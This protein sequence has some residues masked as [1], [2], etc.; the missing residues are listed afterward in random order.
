M[1]TQ[2]QT[3]TAELASTTSKSVTLDATATNGNILI[4]LC[5]FDKDAGTVTAPSGFS[6]AVVVKADI[7]VTLAL[8]YKVSDGTEDTITYT[9]TTSR[10]GCMWVGEY[11]GLSGSTPNVAIITNDNGTSEISTISTGTTGATTQN[12]TLAI[13]AMGSDTATKTD[14]GAAWTNSFAQ[15]A[16]LGS[17][18]AYPGFSVATK[19]LTSTGTVESTFSTTDVGDQMAAIAIVWAEGAGGATVT[20]IDTDGI[21]VDGQ[22]N[23]PFNTTN[24]NDEIS[25][26]K[27]TSGAFTT[28]CT[29]VTSTSGNGNFDI[30]DV[31]A[32]T[33]TT[34]GA[35]FETA[36]WPTTYK[37][38][39]GTDVDIALSDPQANNPK[40]GWL[41]TEVSN[42]S[43]VEGA[44][45]KDL[46]EAV[47]DTSQVLHPDDITIG[48]DGIITT[49]R[50]TNTD[51]QYWKASTGEYI[52]LTIL[53]ESESIISADV[54]QAQTIDEPT[55]NQHN[56]ISSGQCNQSQ[57]LGNVT[58]TQGSVLSTNDINQSQVISS[59]ALIQHNNLSVNNLTQ[60]QATDNITLTVAHVLQVLGLTQSQSI[61]TAA[62][63]QHN[64]LNV[65]NITQNQ[66]V[67]NVILVDN[68]IILSVDDLSQSQLLD[69]PTITKRYTL[70][71]NN[72]TQSQLID[73]VS[74]NV[75]VIGYVK[76]EISIFSAYNGKIKVINPTKIQ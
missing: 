62:L 67:D 64:N 33:S 2:V 56:A 24:F 55:L 28:N 40:S 15:Q 60:S 9:H 6:T 46:G 38:T 35:P 50:T 69:K 51:C 68:A 53:L 29:G 54:S 3:K 16:Y 17:S 25:A 19:S 75:I 73:A 37:L 26:V 43:N 8:C 49:D 4:A 36:S 10:S 57:T 30:P 48:S 41:V 34:V 39:G 52:Q 20:A 65:D 61:D 72:L 31:S 58:L 71:V 23:V 27:I 18:S 32:Y 59:D 66:T 47:P 42:V 14:D 45:S 70:T 7:S 44:F 76:G 5:S 22:Q 13:V 21:T 11:S 12:N 74:T 63:I 1:V